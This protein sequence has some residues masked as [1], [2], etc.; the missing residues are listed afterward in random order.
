MEA[1]RRGR[2][3]TVMSSEQIPNPSSSSSSSSS[4]SYTREAFS[5]SES[6]S[7]FTVSALNETSFSSWTALA[8]PLLLLLLNKLS[9]S[10]SSSSP[11]KECKSSLQHHSLA[12]PFDTQKAP[13]PRQL[14]RTCRR[15]IAAPHWGAPPT[16]CFG[17]FTSSPH[18]VVLPDRTLW[19]LLPT[20]S[21]L[22]IVNSSSSSPNA[23]TRLPYR[24]SYSS[25][26]ADAA[27]KLDEEDVPS[28]LVVGA[29]SLSRT[30]TICRG[31]WERAGGRA[32]GR[33]SGRAG[34]RASEV[35]LAVYKHAHM[36]Y[37]KKTGP[38]KE[39]SRRP[40]RKEAWEGRDL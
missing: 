2:G 36:S 13:Q 31:K 35:T 20:L 27:A 23:C 8:H 39:R 18:N 1:R 10:S 34:G 33:G 11:R 30:S 9:F 29:P 15:D 38:G 12:P 16:S 6:P 32:G 37:E 17:A 28:K 26:A 4:S 3:E 22:L 40:G 25:A 5:R 14:G 7:Q 19:G 24:R 21:H